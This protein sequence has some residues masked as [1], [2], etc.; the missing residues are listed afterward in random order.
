[1][2]KI[3]ISRLDRMGDMILSLPSIKAIKIANPNTLIYV[4]ASHRNAKVLKNLNYI[5]KM[6]VINTS[7][8]F[9]ALFNNIFSIRKLNF[10]FFINL[11]PTILSY[12]FCFF[13][14]SKKKATLIFFSRYKK[15]IFSKLFT[16]L[17]SKIFCQYI[18]I[19]DRYSKLKKHEDIHQTKMIFNLIKI[20]HIPFDSNTD[21]D[22]SLPQEKLKLIPLNKALI[23]IHL[24]DKWINRFY[25]EENFLELI[26]QLPKNKFIYVLTTDH[27]T[28]N[29]F[30]KI[31]N[32]FEIIDNN[33]FVSIKN[34]KDNITILDKLTYENWFNVIYSSNQVI[35]PECGCTHISAACKI[36]VNIIYD[37][38]NLPDA[39]YN[40]YS[41]WKS[42]HKKFVFN[43]KDLNKKIINCLE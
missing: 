18:Y 8:N 31:Y 39:I 37:A 16:R 24:S 28:K 2:N 6:I 4:L 15:S 32:N 27:S 42:K 23:T 30:K 38:D 9:Y 34:L 21:I 20:C 35:T 36:P 1:M 26:A 17:F 40:E 25:T 12:I 19:I 7:S 11:S 5:D 13:S 29:K 43:E 41:P 10:D 33:N 3:C 14:N 22:I